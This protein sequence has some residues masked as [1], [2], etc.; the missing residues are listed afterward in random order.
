MDLNAVS[1]EKVPGIKN[2][3]KPI[4]KHKVKD[5]DG[6]Y[7]LSLCNCNEPKEVKILD[8][9]ESEKSE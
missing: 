6:H 3:L 5:E 1:P 9:E 4:L 7:K 8:L 2:K